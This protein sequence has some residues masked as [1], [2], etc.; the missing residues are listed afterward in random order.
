[1]PKPQD[2]NPNGQQNEQPAQQVEDPSTGDPESHTEPNPNPDTPRKEENKQ[3]VRIEDICNVGAGGFQATCDAYAVDQQKEL[4]YFLS[5]IGPQT[6]VKAIWAAMLNS[7]PAPVYMSD[8]ATQAD[9]HA[10][11]PGEYQKYTIPP[12]TTG[13]WTTKITKLPNK[14]GW[15][16]MVYT[17]MAEFTN[18]NKSFLII[19]R[20]EHEAPTLHYKFMDKRTT[21]PI[22]ESWADWLWDRGLEQG[23]II[24][25]KS[26]RIHGFFCMPDEENLR[27]DLMEAVASGHL[28]LQDTP[29]PIPHNDTRSPQVP[30]T[31]G[32]KPF[33]SPDALKASETPDLHRNHTNPSPMD[34]PLLHAVA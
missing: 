11:A 30:Q 21:I 9:K 4:I 7:N 5:M 33:Q 29:Q 28:T 22:H 14:N 23:E 27:E 31:P 17:K 15:H 1:M 32:P 12:D 16:A 3:L 18:D 2:P 26:L 8:I 20:N 13:T 34:N 25:L 10:T 19:A 6:S 24:P